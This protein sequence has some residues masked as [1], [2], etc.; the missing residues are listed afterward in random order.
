MFSGTAKGETGDG[1]T[2]LSVKD[3]AGADFPDFSRNDTGNTIMDFK[4]NPFSFEFH[5]Y[6]EPQQNYNQ[7]IWV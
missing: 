6:V 1:G 3:S 4:T 5:L 7:V 2:Y